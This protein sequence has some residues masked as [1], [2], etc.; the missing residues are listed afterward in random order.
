MK[1]L[2]LEMCAFGPFAGSEFIDFSRL[3]EQP[4][5]LING[6]TGAG[7][8]TILDAMCFA[9]YGKT[10]GDERD[11]SQMCCDNA[12]PQALTY[13]ELSFEI[14]GKCYRLK[15]IPEQ[16]RPKAK[17][18]GVTKQAAQA[19]LWSIDRQGNELSVIVSQKVTEAT[20]EIEDLI[21]LNAD[22]FRQ[23]MVLPQGQFRKLL[24]A[25]SKDRERIFGQLFSTEIYKQIENRLKDQAL[26]LKR[27]VEKIQHYKSSLLQGKSVESIEQ[28]D[29]QIA[30]L[31]GDEQAANKHKTQQ[32]DGHLNA[33]KAFEQAKHIS[34]AFEQLALLDKR[35][36][37]L[38]AQQSHLGAVKQRELRA[39]AA[40]T[41]AGKHH[42]KQS[43]SL[44][45]TQAQE[46]YQQ[47]I[48][49]LKESQQN[50][51]KAQQEQQQCPQ[52]RQQI[53]QA[54]G[55]LIEFRRYE[56]HAKDLNQLQQ[57]KE[58][59][60]AQLA[61]AQQH[62]A[63]TEQQI[64]KLNQ[65]KLNITQTIERNEAQLSQ[66]VDP[67]VKQLQA[68]QR[69][70][71][72]QAIQS[73]N[74]SLGEHQAQLTELKTKGT[75]LSQDVTLKQNAVKSLEMQ[76]HLSQAQHLAEQLQ[77]GVPCPVC[78]A[79]EH[80][81]PALST[82]DLVDLQQIDIAK[83][84][85]Q[86]WEKQLL[87]QRERYSGCLT[88]CKAIKG[89][90]VEQ[91]ARFDELNEG[92]DHAQHNDLMYWQ[93]ALQVAQQALKALGDH[94]VHVQQA[95]KRIKQLDDL[96]AQ[97]VKLHAEQ[98]DIQAQTQTSLAVTE[99]ELLN[100]ASQLPAAYQAPGALQQAQLAVAQQQK[101]D[102]AQLQRLTDQYNQAQNLL[103]AA[104]AKSNTLKTGLEALQEQ[105]KELESQWL[106][107]LQKSIFEDELQFL[108]ANADA[109]QIAALQAEI[110]NYES[111]RQAIVTEIKVQRERIGESEPPDLAALQH[112][113]EQLLD[114]Q[115]QAE[116]H[117]SLLDRELTGLKETRKQ[118]TEHNRQHQTLEDQY[119]VVGTLADVANG[120]TADK[121][122]LQR[123][124]LSALLDDVLIEASNR[125]HLM[126]QGRYLLLR[127]ES[128]AKGNKASGL[129]LEVDDA[130][131]GKVRPVA[132][133]SGGESFMAALAL[134]L[135][136]SSVVQAYAGG[137]VLE[138]LFI[139]EG[140]GSLDPQALELAIRTLI[141]LQRGGR[142]IGVIS[143]V[144]EL[145]EQIPLRIDISS[146]Q[147]GSHLRLI[148]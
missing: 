121:I 136:L 25:D 124:V 120:A 47:S 60:S 127:K 10:T 66:L 65:E 113:L 81:N 27:E 98:R 37:A 139:D 138:T 31:S 147:Q 16:T 144:D 49:S 112:N 114:Q 4:L 119:K 34:H 128:R 130:Y 72:L 93:Q 145:K 148:D 118:L 58:S 141:D 28:L 102:E 100:C 57:R 80:P 82:G 6:V 70:E 23:V 90:L 88:Q 3:G 140:F 77:S 87:E 76:W 135:G 85:A 46:S 97:A 123:F 84:E 107:V 41:I 91:Q 56:K 33:T 129:E 15:R 36:Q 106:L 53:D 35:S 143:H 79:K 30:K 5:F 71:Q 8:T 105:L 108:Q 92:L 78:G 69:I 44:Q 73:L 126:S 95:Q 75:Q 26:Q 48:T 110:A 116:Q 13:V 131:T 32:Q 55:Q 2:T 59:D 137:I 86:V 125:L 67:E 24:M 40:Q 89:Q 18:E 1:P 117:W 62:V 111:E 29:E 96:Q 83:Q 45:V 12:P 94:K 51:L 14:K 39:Q 115:Q 7:K 132:T 42:E 122:S 134:A 52:I 64:D 101:S 20:R 9:L 43:V 146:D 133:L 68:R 17:G 103:E 50:Q 11:A 99:K 74:Q 61:K 38:K 142:M 63:T 109:S 104:Q 54:K 22:Q 21:G 19:Q